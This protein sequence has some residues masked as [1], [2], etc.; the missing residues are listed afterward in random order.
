MFSSRRFAREQSMRSFGESIL[1]CVAFSREAD[2]SITMMNVGKGPAINILLQQ[3]LQSIMNGEHIETRRGDFEPV[4]P[5]P[6][7]GK[8]MVYTNDGHT[9]PTNMF[10]ARYSNMF[11]DRSYETV[12]EGLK[13]ENTFKDLGARHSRNTR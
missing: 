6:V 3:N 12:F 13:L 11:N 2:L 5:L 8:Y 10:I 1:P 7:G 4:A 9:K